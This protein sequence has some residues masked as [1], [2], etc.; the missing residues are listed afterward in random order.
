MYY[1]LKETTHNSEI[2]WQYLGP[3]HTKQANQLDQLVGTG[4]IIL[5]SIYMRQNICITGIFGSSIFQINL[6][7]ANA[8]LSD[9]RYILKMESRKILQLLSQS[10]FH[11]HYFYCSNT[12]FTACMEYWLYEYAI[13]GIQTIAYSILFNT[14]NETTWS[15]LHFTHNSL[16]IT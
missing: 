1:H 11:L 16:L 9:H 10:S 7:A 8:S 4:E 15:V 13:I 12:Y 3:V 5:Q 14:N 6:F 2:L